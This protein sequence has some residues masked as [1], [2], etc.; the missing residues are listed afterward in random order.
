[1]TE[2]RLLAQQQRQVA[3]LE[4]V[5][6][7]AVRNGTPPEQAVT[8]VRR[9]TDDPV[10]LGLA[11]GRAKGRWSAI[12]LFQSIRQEVAELLIEAGADQDVY[13][14]TASSVERRLRRHVGRD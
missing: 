10:L 7:R 13:T 12:P 1:M 9:I 5:A 4:E 11:A 8:E 2:M 6:R 3:T 14:M